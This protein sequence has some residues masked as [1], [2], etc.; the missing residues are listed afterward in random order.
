MF[1]VLTFSQ[2][3][4]HTDRPTNKLLDF[5]SCS[6]RLD[7]HAIFGENVKPRQCCMFSPNSSVPQSV[8]AAISVLVFPGISIPAP[9]PRTV[10]DKLVATRNL[11]T[12][13]DYGAELTKLL[14]TLATAL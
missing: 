1:I 11:L 6:G 4:R 3:D 8:M 12:G 9:G 10:L 13:K 5:Y 2:T 14:W 7:Y